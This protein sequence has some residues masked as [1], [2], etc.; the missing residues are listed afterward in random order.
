M[1]RWKLIFLIVLILMIVGALGYAEYI[2]FKTKQANHQIDQAIHQMGIP[3]KEQIVIEKPKYNAEVFGNEWFTKVITTKKDYQTWKKIVRTNHEFL[4]GEKLTSKNKGKLDSVS[5]CELT[6]SFT[7]E[8]VNK[9][10]DVDL[11]YGGNSVTKK[12][13]NTYF[14]YKISRK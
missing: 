5:S 3:E 11:V 13:E 14:A 6:Y 8:S 7:Y 9:S 10:V 1:K 12:Q 2:H 4:N